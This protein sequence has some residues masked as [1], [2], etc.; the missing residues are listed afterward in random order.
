MV[1]RANCSFV[2]CGVP[3][4]LELA[5]R[6]KVV[7]GMMLMWLLH[8]SGCWCN[9]WQRRQGEYHGHLWLCQGLMEES[10]HAGDRL[11]T[12]IVAIQPS[13]S[14]GLIHLSTLFDLVLN[15]EETTSN[16]LVD[17]D[18]A[19]AIQA[20]IHSASNAFNNTESLTVYHMKL[21]ED[22]LLS[23]TTDLTA[24]EAQ[25][26]VEETKL[27]QLQMELATWQREAQ[28]L[29][30]QIAELDKKI[31]DADK[32]AAQSRARAERKKKDRWKWIVGTVFSLGLATPG[33]VKNE[34]DIKK[35]KRDRDAWQKQAQQR[36]ESLNVVNNHLRDIAVRQ[37]AVSDL[38]QKTKKNVLSTQS[39]LEG[40]RTQYAILSRLGVQIRSVSTFL[41]SLNGEMGVVYRQ[42][43]LMVLFRPLLQSVE[44]LYFENYVMEGSKTK[45]RILS[46]CII[47][48]KRLQ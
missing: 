40:L 32:R 46:S 1:F 15:Y 44:I 30:H 39:I 23:L 27:V 7:K 12:K 19:S 24:K 4:N 21:Y 10:F 6:Y 5:V 16:G 20:A 11:Q 34:N 14:H 9:I 43:Q 48:R 47:N 45:G 35:Q 28:A 42:H 26:R 3:G 17:D 25:L 36:R 22:G 18:T 31:I 38:M 29:G 8:R 41:V 33:L 13:F 37:Q 2:A